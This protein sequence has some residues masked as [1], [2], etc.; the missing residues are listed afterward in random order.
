MPR[1]RITDF[2]GSCYDASLTHEGTHRD[3][4]CPLAAAQ[5]GDDGTELKPESSDSK[6]GSFSTVPWLQFRVFLFHAFLQMCYWPLGNLRHRIIE[7]S[8][9]LN[10]AIGRWF[11]PAPDF[12]INEAL[13]PLPAI[14]SHDQDLETASPWKRGGMS[15]C[16]SGKSISRP[17]G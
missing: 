2:R 9:H 11:S 13:L 10:Y 15:R 12:E 4:N 5:L 1:I 8:D 3:A 17:L 6:C 7:G 14:R 16:K